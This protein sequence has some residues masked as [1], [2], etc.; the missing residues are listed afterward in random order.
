MTCDT[1]F[2]SNISLDLNE[3]TPE[4]LYRMV[5]EQ[6]VDYD[7]MLR[8]FQEVNG[9][10]ERPDEMNLPRKLPVEV[11]MSPTSV[12]STNG[13][14]LRTLVVDTS[15]AMWTDFLFADHPPEYVRRLR[16]ALGTWG[17]TIKVVEFVQKSPVH[18][19]CLHESIFTALF[20]FFSHSCPRATLVDRIF[21]T[22]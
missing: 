10:H 7:D 4:G 5:E 21:P 2:A 1:T 6:S 18:D 12:P 3:L 16:L 9:Q 20:Y 15:D 11:F 17:N 14:P 19:S 22:F 13:V 8:L